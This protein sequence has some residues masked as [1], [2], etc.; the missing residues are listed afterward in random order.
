M[1]NSTS[2]LSNVQF[3]DYYNQSSKAKPWNIFN[4]YLLNFPITWDRNCPG[5]GTGLTILRQGLDEWHFHFLLF[6]SLDKLLIAI[7]S[8]KSSIKC[9][10]HPTDA[11]MTPSLAGQRRERGLTGSLKLFSP[12]HRSPDNRRIQEGWNLYSLLMYLTQYIPHLTYIIKQYL[13]HYLYSSQRG[14]E[15]DQQDFLFYRSYSEVKG[16]W[17]PIYFKVK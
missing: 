5:Q 17:D 11:K 1:N 2:F 12:G 3:T 9:Q 13:M 8:F 16:K 10:F 6:N 7:S 4:G 14:P 15:H